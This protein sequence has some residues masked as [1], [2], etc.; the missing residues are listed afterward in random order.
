M[1]GLWKD[2]RKHFLKDKAR[3]VYHKF[4]IYGKYKNNNVV[5]VENNQTITK[6]VYRVKYFESGYEK[7]I[8]TFDFNHNTSNIFI[9]GKLMGAHF[10]DKYFLGNKRKWACKMVKHSNK[11][12][13]RTFVSNGDWDK[14]IKTHYGTKSVSWMVD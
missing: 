7:V 11:C 14:P 2:K 10:Y 4:G 13:F 12:H 6:T 9:Y 5:R 1:Q 8:K 3:V